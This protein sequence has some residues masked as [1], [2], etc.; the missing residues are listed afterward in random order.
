MAKKNNKNN[1]EVVETQVL[2]DGFNL[3]DIDPNC[4]GEGVEVPNLDEF[5]VNVEELTEDEAKSML[6]EVFSINKEIIAEKTAL[7]DKFKELESIVNSTKDSWYRC[8][9]EFENYKKRNEQTRKFAYD[10]G[11]KDAI[12]SLLLI[13]DSLDRALSLPMDDKTKEG[14]LL[15]QKQFVESLLALG[16]EE[17][18]PLGETFNPET[19]EAIATLPCGEGETPDTVKQVYK[20]GYKMSGKVIRY[21]QVIVLQ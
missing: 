9:A 20:K 16:V 15:I 13:G 4:D 10:D 17:I 19:A 5:E 18:N 1:E 12:L 11:K 2:E 3:D 14:V 6:K 8:A 21:A 7:L